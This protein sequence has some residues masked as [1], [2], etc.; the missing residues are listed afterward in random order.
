MGAIPHCKVC[1]RLVPELSGQFEV[2][3]SLYLDPSTREHPA[4]QLVGDVHTKCLMESEHGAQWAAWQEAH[5]EGRG[6][7][8]AYTDGDWRV[9]IDKWRR[10]MLAVHARGATVYAEYKTGAKVQPS[11]GGVLLG[12][13]SQEAHLGLRDKAVVATLQARVRKGPLPMSEFCEIAGIADRMQWPQALV[14]ATMK[15]GKREQKWWTDD[16]ISVIEHYAAFL[17]D[18]TLAAWDTLSKLP[19]RPGDD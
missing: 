8:L 6:F 19:A 1:K 7:Q 17:P 5:Y 14:G 12:L 2:L 10:Y 15:A 9:L 18:A 11:D 13:R 4:R 3:D 16:S